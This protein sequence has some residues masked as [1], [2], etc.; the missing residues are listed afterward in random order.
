MV[1]YSYRYSIAENFNANNYGFVND[2]FRENNIGSGNQLG[3]GKA[4]MG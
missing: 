3:L 2:R 1:G 4:G